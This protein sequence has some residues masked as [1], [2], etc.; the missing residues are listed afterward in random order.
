MFGIGYEL[1]K[2]TEITLGVGTFVMG[3][4]ISRSC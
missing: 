4:E 1:C 3:Y 2:P